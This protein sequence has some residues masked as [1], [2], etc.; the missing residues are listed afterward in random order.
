MFPPVKR[1]LTFDSRLSTPSPYT[2]TVSPSTI[3]PSFTS[4]PPRAADGDFLF[5]GRRHVFRRHVDNPVGVDVERDLDLRHAARRLRETDQL[6]SAQRPIVASQRTLALEHMNFH[7]GL[8]VGGRRER[9][10]L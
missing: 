8:I 7:V 3:S 6:E 5:L 10:T 1:L 2:P 9:L 4:G